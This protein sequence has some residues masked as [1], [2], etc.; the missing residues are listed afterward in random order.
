MPQE[1]DG[2]NH[3]EENST[4]SGETNDRF[5]SIAAKTAS[6]E[7]KTLSRP[8]NIKEKIRTRHL[9]FS[10]N[11][12]A[13][14]VS[15][16]TVSLHCRVITVSLQCHYIT[17]QC[18]YSVITVGWVSTCLDQKTPVRQVP[19]KVNLPLRP[20]PIK[21]WSEVRP[22]PISSTTTLVG[23]RPALEFFQISSNFNPLTSVVANLQ[24]TFAC[25]SIYHTPEGIP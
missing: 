5:T 7:I 2:A 10:T 19:D 15:V 21:K 8:E 20:R 16:I 18:Y 23:R 1:E 4:V 6:N 17:L 24:H 3:S 25:I 9:E 11:A 22:R 14:F 13:W 12:A